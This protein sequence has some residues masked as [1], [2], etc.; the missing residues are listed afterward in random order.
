MLS[1]NQLQD[2]AY[3]NSLIK[4]RITDPDSFHVIT[5]NEHDLH[6]FN[7]RRYNPGNDFRIATRMI[8][9]LLQAHDFTPRPPDDS[10]PEYGRLNI[11]TAPTNT[12]RGHYHSLPMRMITR[13]AVFA[14]ALRHKKSKD[15]WRYIRNE[16]GLKVGEPIEHPEQLSSGKDVLLLATMIE[17]LCL[18]L[19]SPIF[20]HYEA[21]QQDYEYFEDAIAALENA[22]APAQSSVDVASLQQQIASLQQ[23]VMKLMAQL[24]A[25]G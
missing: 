3:V 20:G 4:G 12:I 21:Q 13:M 17:M 18:S 5:Y 10:R 8:D 1:Q 2:I 16:G 14:G 15:E 9:V 7:P 25:K 23:M 11:G 24:Q 6:Q 19:G 22:I